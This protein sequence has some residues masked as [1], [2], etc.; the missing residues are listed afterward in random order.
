MLL[1]TH[2]KELK[3]K[4]TKKNVG[5]NIYRWSDDSE[6]IISSIIHVFQCHIC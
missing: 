6:E 5:N 1:V 4:E 3:Q 2:D